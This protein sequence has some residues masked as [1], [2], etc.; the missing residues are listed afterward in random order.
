MKPGDRRNF[1]SPDCLKKAI[2]KETRVSGE[3]ERSLSL[4]KIAALL[5]VNGA[6]SQARP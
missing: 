1:V 6:A 2:A 4:K 5:K 3:L